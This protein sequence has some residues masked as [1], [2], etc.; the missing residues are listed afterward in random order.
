MS[1]CNQLWQMKD[2][3]SG[4]TF[5]EKIITLKND[6]DTPID[7]TDCTFLFEFRKAKIGLNDNPV[8]FFWSS[9]DNSIEIVDAEN[10]QLKLNK[11]NISV[12]PSDYVSDFQITYANE[13]VETLFNAKI[14]VIQSI[15][16]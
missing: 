1:K 14:R 15:S 13:D 9:S 10:G 2:H 7:I 8:S 3:V 11:Q 12:D 16:G 4:D 5:K 6:N